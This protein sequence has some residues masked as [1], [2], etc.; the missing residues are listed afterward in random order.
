MTPTAEARIPR[1][2]SVDLVVFLRTD[3]FE[4]YDSQEK[5]KLVS[6]SLE[7]AWSEEDWLEC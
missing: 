6:R 1:L 3:V 4:L 2:D 5:N 7:L